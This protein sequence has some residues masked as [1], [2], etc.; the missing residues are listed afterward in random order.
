MHIREIK[1]KDC[2]NLAALS[3]F[4]WLHTYAKEGIRD[5]ISEFVL[6][7]FTKDKYKEIVQ[8]PI[9]R[10]FVV[11][12]D[13]HIIG[14]V[15]VDLES[16]YS[17]SSKFGYEIET[18]YVHPNFQGKGVG[19]NLL[20]HLNNCVGERSWLTTWVHNHDAIEFYKK[21]GYK[22][23]GDTEFRLINESHRNHV[24]SNI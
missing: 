14:V 23:I 1:E 5:K 11:I 19:K 15:I 16:K 21:N 18:L 8:S 10:G 17:N 3:I 13:Q 24:L 4:V 9:K 2:E 6:S 7:T 12:S 22:I 20:I